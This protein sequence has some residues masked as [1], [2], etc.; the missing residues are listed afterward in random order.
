M[1]VYLQYNVTLYIQKSVSENAR[2]A[3]IGWENTK[4]FGNPPPPSPTD[5]FLK[6]ARPYIWQL[7]F[8]DA[9]GHQF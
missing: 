9:I 1:Q 6:K 2:N 7:Q 5:E 8:R 3:V 4:H